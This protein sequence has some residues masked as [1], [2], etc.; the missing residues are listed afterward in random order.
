M[1]LDVLMKNQL[2][3]GLVMPF[4]PEIRQWNF[5]RNELSFSET[6]EMTMLNEEYYETLNA[7]KLVDRVDGLL[8]YGFVLGGTIAKWLQNPDD[9]EDT[10]LFM[11]KYCGHFIDLF[12]VVSKY[13]VKELGI[14]QQKIPEVLAH[15]MKLV[16]EANER[17]GTIKNEA[18]KI[19]KPKDFVGPEDAL[20]SLLESY[21]EERE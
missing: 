14:D 13:M 20:S 19:V 9:S 10:M 21:R 11:D 7:E 12:I 18:G 15:G 16:I 1:L 17:K 8:D 3:D 6:L 5:I 4:F 2:V